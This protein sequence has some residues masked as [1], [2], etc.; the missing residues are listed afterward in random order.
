MQRAERQGRYPYYGASGIIDYV[1]DFLF[2]GEYILVSEDGENLRSRNTPIAFKA[3]GKFWVNNHAHI[4]QGRKA[5]LNDLLIYYFQNLDLHPYITGA[6]QPKLNKANLLSIP[7]FLPQTDEEQEAIAGVLGSLD[8]K[9]DL[10]QRQNKTLEGLAQT[11]FRHWFVDGAEDDWEEILG[12]LP[13]E[14]VDGDRGKNYPKNTEFFPD[15]YCLFLSAKNV[16]ADGFNFDERSFITKDKDEILRSGKLKRQD[17]VLTTRGTVGNIAFYHPLVEYD[18]VRI[19]SGMVLLRSQSPEIPPLFLYIQMKS[20]YFSMSIREHT[21]G[22]AQPQLPIRDMRNLPMIVPPQKVLSSYMNV[23]SKLYDKVH[24]N[25]VQIRT[26]EKL[27]NVLLPKL[28]SGEV[29]VRQN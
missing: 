4:L 28:M 15:E 1:D 2:D 22:S 3:T 29:R 13:V 11:L 20:P 17:L 24:V 21:S 5:H 14:I 7:V 27:R 10:L 26:L 8:E 25:Q 12:N 23:A 6:V 18:N 16:T 19:N 9:I